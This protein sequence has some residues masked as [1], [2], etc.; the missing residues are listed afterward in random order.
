MRSLLV[1][2]FAGAALALTTIAAGQDRT[3]LSLGEALDLA[4]RANPELI[5]LQR[6]YEA[7]SAAIPE[8]RF[9]EPP[10]FEAQIWDWPVTTLNPARTDMYMFTAEQTFPGRGKRAARELVA[11][12]EAE[13]SQQQIAV[14]ANGILAE[15]RQVYAELLLARATVDL[16]ARQRPL[17]ED[18]AEA[19]TLRYASGHS[20][21]H[22]TVKAIV[23]LSRLQSDAIQWRERA[24]VAETRLN[25][26]LG[27]VADSPVPDLTVV[28]T[29]LP[30]LVDAEQMAVARN[31]DVAM[32]DALIA[33]EEAELTRLH[34][35]RRPDVVVG[36]GYMLQPGGA[37]AWT[38]RG[39][40][41][42]PNAPWSRGRLN[43]NIDAQQ[44]RV[45]AARAQRDAVL[46]AVRR[47]LHEALIRA[48]AARDR[49]QVL[50]TSVTP[51]IEHAFDIARV[52]YASDRGDFA[53]LLDTQRLLLATRIDVVAARAE[54]A[55]A[56]ADLQMALG[57]QEEGQR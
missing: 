18:T 4:R 46:A 22:D 3:A 17:I 30:A 25:V 23:E 2:L 57:A 55:M 37:G 44:Q 43:T 36:G 8:S 31:P 5:A 33:R 42:W 26:L 7:A 39:G 51:H 50:D 1:S 41:T 40:I 20:G 24:R 35:E 45:I 19:A 9:L 11:K 34:G 10:M 52:A 47:Q 27:R 38:A 13:M 12:R 6:Q 21:Q 15:V 32:A 16:Y 56:V 14:R 54:Y 29:P 53:D 49:V 48:Q 28:D